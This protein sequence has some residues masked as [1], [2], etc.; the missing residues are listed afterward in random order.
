MEDQAFQI[1]RML[2]NKLDVYKGW[3]NQYVEDNILEIQDLYKDKENKKEL[4]KG[5]VEEEEVILIRLYKV[6]ELISSKSSSTTK[7]SF[8]NNKV[9]NLMKYMKFVWYPTQTRLFKPPPYY[10][11]LWSKGEQDPDF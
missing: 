2:A 7:L 3:E 8:I 5:R 4:R 1:Q 6:L 10:Q 9:D 11:G